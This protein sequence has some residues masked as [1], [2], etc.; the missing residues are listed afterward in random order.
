MSTRPLRIGISPC[1]NDTFA[2]H[3]L[4]RG[5]VRLRGLELEI[6][7]AD[8]EELNARLAAGQYDA[9][10]ASF[11]AALHMGD[12]LVVLRSG[13][14]LGFGV[15][16]LLVARAGAPPLDGAR[17]LCPGARTTAHLLYQLFHRGQG[18]VEQTV[19]SRI[20]PALERGEADYGVCIH[21]GR[22]TYARHGLVS[23]EDLGATWE[24]RVG[25]PL[26][27]GGIVA[28]KSLGTDVLHALD[29][30]IRDSLDHAR[31]HPVDALALMREHAVEL[32]AASIWQHVELYVNAWTRDLGAD[33]AAALAQLARSARAAGLLPDQCPELG[34]LAARAP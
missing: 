19:F 20:L 26:P 2:F 31:A 13:S 1:P 11:S 34:V 18:H 16:P 28:R 17:V 27:L 24:R 15:G 7:F 33:G 9:A 23:V 4:I 10:K 22:F 30:A 12:E 32:D 14:A 5:A 6:D 25:C 8:V 29:D 21:E 3:G